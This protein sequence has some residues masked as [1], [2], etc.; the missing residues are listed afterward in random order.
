MQRA[1][2]RND[3]AVR[4]RTRRPT[5]T[6]RTTRAARAV[7]VHRMTTGMVKRARPRRAG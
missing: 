3:S 7:V 4:R 2:F 5:S 1:R 6:Y